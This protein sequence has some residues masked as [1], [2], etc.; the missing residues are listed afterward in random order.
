LTFFDSGM[1]IKRWVIASNIKYAPKQTF[2]R[3]K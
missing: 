1:L 3:G 2:S